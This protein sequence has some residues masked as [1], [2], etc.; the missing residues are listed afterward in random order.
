VEIGVD[1]W[2]KYSRRRPERQFLSAG[3]PIDSLPEAKIRPDPAGWLAS[4]TV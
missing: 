4:R 3:T 1:A 2:K